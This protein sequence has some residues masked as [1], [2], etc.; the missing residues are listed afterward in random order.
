MSS[1][2]R[3]TV[4][5][6]TLV[7]N[8]LSA[9]EPPV[10]IVS[11]NGREFDFPILKA[12]IQRVG[13]QIVDGL[14]CMDSLELFKF[15]PQIFGRQHSD[16]GVASHENTI[17]TRSLS[18]VTISSTTSTRRRLNFSPIADQPAAE[19]TPV[20]REVTG[21]TTKVKP[22]SYSLGNVYKRLFLRSITAAHS[23]EG[24][25]IA[26]LQIF[27]KTYQD[28]KHLLSQHITKYT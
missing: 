28:L 6:V 19:Q 24:D 4:S 3:F 27:H 15:N 23:A 12:E 9:N 20:K 10:C 1:Q 21:I 16:L 5:S 14:L 17:S 25:C 26:L 11:H 18:P 8:F 22:D 13:G 2:Q 7:N